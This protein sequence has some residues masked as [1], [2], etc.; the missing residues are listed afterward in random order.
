MNNARNNFFVLIEQTK[1][2]AVLFQYIQERRIP[3]DASDLLRWEWVL[4]VSAFDKYIHDIIRV[5]MLEEFLGRR[6]ET[7][8]YRNFRINISSFSLMMNSSAPELEFEKEIIQQLK[9]NS[10]QA[11]EKVAD[12]LSYIW[13]ENH[14]WRVISSN[15][16]N[17]IS[18]NDLRIKLNNIV[19]RRNQIA[20]EGDCIPSV[21][22]YQQE[23]ISEIDTQ[24]V[25][26]FISELVDAIH[27]S[28]S[29]I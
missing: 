1:T 24:D 23:V 21:F 8:K 15:M 11:P 27:V 29:T 16:R 26:S 4:A 6:P 20:H 25:V 18:E 5:G 22:P 17:S 3:I 10:Y 14:K 7:D 2:S 28:V 9:T 13:S 12:G 19:L